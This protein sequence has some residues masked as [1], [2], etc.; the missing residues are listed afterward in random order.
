MLTT[1][2][3][4]IADDLAKDVSGVGGETSG[5]LRPVLALS[6]ASPELSAACR[7][8]CLAAHHCSPQEALSQRASAALLLGPASQMCL[9]SS[10]HRQGRDLLPWLLLPRVAK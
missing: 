6:G 2:A 3:Y 5:G 8:G 9:V 1:W 10:V 4:V 7:R